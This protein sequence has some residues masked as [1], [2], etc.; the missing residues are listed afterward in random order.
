MAT[1]AA[2]DLGA[3]SGRVAVGRFDGERLDVTEV[4]RFPNAPVAEGAT[5]HWDIDRLYRETFDGLRAAGAEGGAVDSIG[6][7][8]WAVDF[9]LVDAHGRLVADP[10]AYRD[11]RRAAAVDDVLAKVPARELYE[12]TGIQI[13][14]I[15]TIFELAAMAADA[16]PGLAG[17]ETLLMIPDLVNNRLAGTRVSEYTNAT[18]TQCLDA[19]S[20]TWAE[21]ILER[22]AVPARILPELVRPGTVLG[23]LTPSASGETQLGGARV[24]AVA[25]H[26]TASAVAAIPLRGAA[27]AYISAGT[28][29][30]VG[31][32]VDRPLIDDRTFAANL[33]N[34]GGVGGTFR[35][36]RNVTGLWLLHECRRA[37]A[38]SG[39]AYTF[40]ELVALAGDAPALQALIEPNDPVFAA[41]GDMP[42]RIRDFCAATGQ[43]LPWDVGAVARCILES[44]ALKHAQ[45]LGVLGDAT[46]VAP[47]EIHIVGGGARNALLCRFTADAAGLP[48]VAGPEE[49]TLLGNLLVQAIALGEI[50]SVA[51]GREVVRR[52]FEATVYEPFA[53][54]AWDGARHRF[55]ELT[56]GNGSAAEVLA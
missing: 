50:G 38:E 43:I 39:D 36:L 33:T 8:S 15:N 9:G 46:G 52:S 2:V 27:S 18:T 3:Q 51:E 11:A 42:G 41:P 28:W 21:D 14:P 24:V 25:S 7:D 16:D 13:I 6:V 34:E 17:A 44:L 23:S 47:A 31:V 4:H 45:T 53:S 35:L 26:D 5:L 22:L 49:A 19:A 29:S 48:V 10:V 56:V 30:L 37:W 12:R 55:A 40:D 20:G 1:M 54:Q 32:E